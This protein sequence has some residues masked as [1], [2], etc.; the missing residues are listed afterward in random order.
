M[1]VKN[2]TKVNNFL[3]KCA[4]ESQFIYD[5][6]IMLYIDDYCLSEGGIEEFIEYMN[7]HP[8][9][10]ILYRISADRYDY[11]TYTFD[12]PDS[13]LTKLKQAYKEYMRDVNDTKKIEEE[14]EIES[15]HIKAQLKG[16]KLVKA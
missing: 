12:D 16:Y 6:D 1:K 9:N 3:K 15:L 8:G 14:A 2:A 5:V 11:Y 10:K 7:N 13:I 4:A